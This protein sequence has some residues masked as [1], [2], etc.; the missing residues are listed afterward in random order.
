MWTRSDL[1]LCKA[2]AASTHALS[3]LL[4]LADSLHRAGFVEGPREDVLVCKASQKLASPGALATGKASSHPDRFSASDQ[5]V[6]L[7][8]KSGATEQGQGC[9]EE[10]RSACFRSGCRRTLVPLTPSCPSPYLYPGVG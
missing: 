4:P 1:N 6:E 9:S 2:Q 8:L 3:G 5:Q 10:V 7:V